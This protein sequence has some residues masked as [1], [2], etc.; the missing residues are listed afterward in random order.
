MAALLSLLR[1]EL[2]QHGPALL[3]TSLL[4]GLISLLGW[5]G[6]L[7]EARV[8]T[9]LDIVPR[10]AITAL[11]AAALY[12]GHRLVVAE[13]YGR[14]QRFLEALPVRRGAMVLV[15]AAFGLAWLLLWAAAAL[16]LTARAA[17][18][19]E[20]IAPRF[21]AIMSARLGLY[22]FA[23]WGVVFLFGFF[24]RLRV[25]LAVAAAIVL[26]LLNRTTAM[27][28]GRFGPLALID[29]ASF[30][31]ERHHF[32]GR[33][34]AQAAAMGAVGL[35]LAY[36]L[37]RVRDGSVV[38]SLARRLSAR[39]L[40]ALLVMAAGGATLVGALSRERPAPEY[41]FTTDAVLT[42]PAGA[43][44]I[45]YFDE[46][47]RPEAARLATMLEEKIA[48]VERLLALPQRLP[49]VRLVQGPEVAPARPRVV[50]NDDRALVVRVQLRDLGAEDEVQL[51]ARVLHGLLWQR[52]RGRA[53]Y[54]PK[55][56]LLDGFSLNVARTGEPGP[57]LTDPPDRDMLRAVA[58]T[59]LERFDERALADY[60]TT[61]DRIGD[62]LA[63][64]LAATG[65][66]VLAAR[67]GPEK[68]RALARAALA[69][70]GT[71]DFR[72]TLHDRRSPMPA[73]FEESTGWPWPE[74]VR[75][76]GAALEAWGQTAAARDALASW[77]RGA[78]EARASV[79]DGVGVGA[80]LSAPLAAPLTC[81][82]EH[83]KLPP[84]D[85]PVDPDLLD[86]VGFLWPTGSSDLD[87]VVSGDY[88]RGERAY[89]VLECE[90]PALGGKTRLFSARVT[91][92]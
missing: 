18:A 59:R 91:V 19:T 45:A 79:R 2:R 17:H 10:F 37:A 66:R 30:P 27:H 20:P 87:R 46:E 90:L 16:L 14:T 84:Y 29:M 9:V 6:Q 88:G 72:D 71:D 15:K 62:D 31:F 57:P 81:A 55:H 22:V 5:V 76:W 70:R 34:L 25:P 86:E 38:E 39:E 12:L 43:V 7:K 78:F 63:L 8:L 64:S 83:I 92:R 48:T 21:L 60:D 47:L 58:A 52:T 54:E 24:G 61:S 4:L 36:A 69:R 44:E 42:G 40:S 65:W 82:L 35:A 26:F 80:Q 23:L 1:K 49:K 28:L 50:A 41:R 13:Y 56:W 74:L 51:A 73:L 53:A 75:S 89:V 68:T 11:P 85:A 32:P 77:P 67:V 3:A 33:A